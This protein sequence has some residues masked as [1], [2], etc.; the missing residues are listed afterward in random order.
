MCSTASRRPGSAA[1]MFG[2]VGGKDMPFDQP[3]VLVAAGIAGGFA[4]WAVAGFSAGFYKP[5]FRSN[6]PADGARNHPVT[7]ARYSVGLFIAVMALVPAAWPVSCWRRHALDCAGRG[8]SCPS[9]TNT[10]ARTALCRVVGVLLLAA[11]AAACDRCGDFVPPVRFM[12]DSQ[13]EA[14]RDAAPKL[15]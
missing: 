15:R 8:G 5:I 14:C 3:L 9:V 7:R 6:P 1:Q 4:Y 12:A 10:S 11:T 2:G 13:P